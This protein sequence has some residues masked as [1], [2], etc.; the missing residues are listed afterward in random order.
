MPEIPSHSNK[1]PDSTKALGLILESLQLGKTKRQDQLMKDHLLR[2]DPA[3]I[4]K[5][6]EARDYFEFLK[7]LATH[8]Y[9]LS[10]ITSGAVIT[11]FQK[12]MTVEQ[13]RKRLSDHFSV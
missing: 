11:F 10:D 9:V 3:L 2:L 7:Y 13:T 4:Q 8:G 12:R 1:V 5:I 6:F